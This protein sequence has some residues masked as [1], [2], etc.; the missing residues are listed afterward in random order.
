[1]PEETV[2][3][4]LY[5]DA[6]QSTDVQDHCGYGYCWWNLF[7]KFGQRALSLSGRVAPLAPDDPLERLAALVHRDTSH[8]YSGVTLLPFS[9]REPR[10]A[11][12]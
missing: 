11:K 10:R 12:C 8:K 5:S 4:L 7:H 1:M 6:A 3:L 9:T 2:P